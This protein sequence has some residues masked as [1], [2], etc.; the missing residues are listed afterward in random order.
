MTN[1]EHMTSNEKEPLQKLATAIVERVGLV[2]AQQEI[3]SALLRNEGIQLGLGS[4][5]LPKDMSVQEAL[6]KNICGLQ[7]LA[8][9]IL[10]RENRKAKIEQEKQI[11]KP[12][13]TN[14]P[15]TQGC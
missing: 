11:A 5:I 1:K 4:V 2:N 14:S 9:E 6:E 7:D 12:N 3:A 10:E 13:K 8:N 15:K